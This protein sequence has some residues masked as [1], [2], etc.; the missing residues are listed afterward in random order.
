MGRESKERA[1]RM[2]M[3]L[4][5]GDYVPPPPSVQ[6]DIRDR[7]LGTDFFDIPENLDIRDTWLME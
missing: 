2:F 4:G 5:S 7:W 6:G 3:L 1:R